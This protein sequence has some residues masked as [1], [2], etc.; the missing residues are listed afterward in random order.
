VKRALLGLVVLV[1]GVTIVFL[2]MGLYSGTGSAAGLAN[3]QLI[4]CPDKPNC[5]SSES[6]PSDKHSIAA[7][8]V[9]ETMGE[10]PLVKVR[11]VV[12]L[13]GGK[14]SYSDEQ[15]LA[16]TFTS[17]LFGFV[18]DVEL[19]L[20]RDKGVIHVRSASRVGYSDLGANRKRVEQIRQLLAGS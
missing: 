17:A 8:Q 10:Q 12:E 20:D 11:E 5:V 16:S 13:L 7:I 6:A 3:G 15:Y 9:N 4:P 19:R 18:D 1:A 14:V 2:A